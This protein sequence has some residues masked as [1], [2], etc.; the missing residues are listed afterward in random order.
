VRRL[1][2]LPEKLVL[3]TAA[4]TVARF[5]EVWRTEKNNLPLSKELIATIE[6]HVKTVPI[7]QA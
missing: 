1:A 2:R 4:E 3:D 7:A 5:H 6:R